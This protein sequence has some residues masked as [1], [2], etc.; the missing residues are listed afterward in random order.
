MTTA[1]CTYVV[2]VAGC[3]DSTR[4]LVDLTGGEFAAVAK[5][6]E[7][8]NAASKYSCQPTMRIV[9]REDATE[10]DLGG[11]AETEEL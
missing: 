6:A 9:P 7:A 8:V 10:L 4:I 2:R 1:V 3:D 11:L 5:V